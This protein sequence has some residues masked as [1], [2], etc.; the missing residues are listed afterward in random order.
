MEIFPTIASRSETKVFPMQNSSASSESALADLVSLWQRRRAEGQAPTPTELCR[1][2]PELL[3]EL[4]QR[5]AA[6]ERMADLADAIQ[7]TVTVTPASSEVSG[8]HEGAT[9][10]REAMLPPVSPG[11]VA[12]A[13]ETLAD[14]PV[15]PGYELLGVLGKGGMG[16]V[17][18]ARQRGL[19]RVVALKMIL[20]A[21][22]ADEEER[23]RF[24]TEAE[25]VAR[26][27]HPNIVQI[28]EVGEHK[29]LP[30]FSLEFC[31]GGGLADK[32]NG[33]PLTP[34]EAARLVQTL[35]VAMQAAHDKDLL[36]R[37]LK[38]ANVLLAEDGTLKITDFGLAKKL[39]EQGQTPTGAVIG[40]PSYMAPEQASGKS[41]ELGPACDIYALGAIL[42]E[43][44]TGRPPFKAATPV[45]TVLQVLN[46]EAV[47][48][49]QLQPQTPGD[50]GTICHKCLQK[51]PHKRYASGGELAED[52]R[53]FLEGETIHARPVGTIERGWRWCRRNQTLAGVSGLATVF[54]VVATGVSILLALRQAESA[55]HSA[56]VAEAL[57][58][59]QAQTET[60]LRVAR[61]Q[62]SLLALERGLTSCEQGGEGV[63]LLWFARSLREAP[64]ED[65]DLQRTIRGFIS[66][67]AIGI[68][69]LAA[70]SHHQGCVN[71]VAISP[72]GGLM[73]KGSSDRTARVWE[74]KTG[75]PSSAPLLHRGRV[76]AVAFSP[77]GKQVLTGSEDRTAGLWDVATGES[78]GLN[79]LHPGEVRAVAF[80]PDGK[81]LLTG[82]T[83]NAARLWDVAT[84]KLLAT[85]RLH[86]NTVKAVAFSP[87]GTRLVTGSWDNTVQQW[88]ARSGRPWGRQ[89]SHRNWINAVAYSPDGKTLATA[90]D[91]HTAC[92]WDAETGEPRGVVLPHNGGVFAAA[93]SSDGRYILTG[94]GDH[95][96]MLWEA[97]TGR[98]AGLPLQHQSYVRAVAFSPDGRSLLTGC[99]DQAARVWEAV[100]AKP[101]Q[102]PLPHAAEVRAVAF[103]PDGRILLTDSEDRVVRRWQ[104]TTGRVLDSPLRSSEDACTLAFGHDDK[105][106]LIGY[107][108]GTAR[109]WDASTGK[110]LGTPISLPGMLHTATLSPDDRTLLA[111]C[112]GGIV[113]LGRLDSSEIPRS[114][115]RLTQLVHALA[116]SPDGTMFATG[117]EDHTAR[118]W[119]TTT[120]KPLTPPLKHQGEVYTVAFSPNGQK[121]ITGSGDQTARLW[122]AKSG[123]PLGLPLKHGDAVW[124]VAFS[125]DGKMVLTGSGD[126]TARLWDVASCQPLAPP[127]RHNDDVRAVAFSLD[128]RT[129]LTGSLDQTARQ[130]TIYPPVEG[131]VGRITLWASL[132]T[133]MELGED[134]S[135]RS[136]HADV[137]RS[138]RQQLH[139][140]SS[141]PAESSLRP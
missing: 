15:V 117:I 109:L 49:R 69:P 132:L 14:G 136:L 100:P 58:T 96:A 11:Q 53:R 78:R 56:E 85:L 99:D 122:D 107:K 124:A 57:A 16:I 12:P 92:L 43:C 104:A 65:G 74:V 42:Y 59:K 108:D 68:H 27:Q 5:I 48:V 44:L 75:N 9:L 121:L 111:A 133:G 91:D 47:S 84:G 106:V 141:F 45:E 89:L 82:C 125:P 20:H 97:R 31:P 115:C 114:K 7:E 130:W 54:L 110:P 80:H 33:T 116:I 22:H 67:T 140:V 138:Y 93:F 72:D 52:L 103:S 71:A 88:D 137:W 86:N 32:L 41:K 94:S 4:E 29:G 28:H 119:D 62:S 51:E 26:L 127:F 90:S 18:K 139:S 105:V 81:T 46:Q 1:D 123:Q 50:L 95:R 21:D 102:A 66:N 17:Y 30:Y 118:L 8:V 128:G 98:P 37:D 79:L 2:R 39:G 64:E 70:I 83:D 23:Q 10:D 134:N 25:A 131:E 24:Q 6:V 126:K 60:A 63:G 87:D 129:I 112:K 113:V 73:L 38:P 76:W 135:L 13:V 77:D 19:G 35:A 36:H 61:H 34:Q 55:A 40:T 3:P 120:G 101:A